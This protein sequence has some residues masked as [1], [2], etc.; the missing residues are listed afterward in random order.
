MP[1]ALTPKP[2]IKPWE[3]QVWHV[4]GVHQI[5]IERLVVS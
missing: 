4:V 2:E 1:S 3:H 5:F